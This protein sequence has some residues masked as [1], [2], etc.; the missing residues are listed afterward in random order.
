V[1]DEKHDLIAAYDRFS[2]WFQMIESV[3]YK[4]D[5]TEK[6]IRFMRK[7]KPDIHSILDCACGIGSVAI[8]LAK[9]GFMVSCSDASEGMLMYAKRDAESAGTSAVRFYKSDW[10]NLEENVVGKFDCIINLG[11][12]IYHLDGADLLTAL[13]SMKV[14]LNPGGL[15]IL[16]N[17]NWQEILC[18]NEGKQELRLIEKR[19]IVRVFNG[20]SPLPLNKDKRYYFFDIAWPEGRQWIM[21]V[22]RLPAKEVHELL[23]KKNIA[24]LN[25]DNQPISIKIQNGIF[26]ARYYH[27]RLGTPFDDLPHE[28]I[29]ISGWPISSSNLAELMEQIGF[30][31]IK[32]LDKYKELYEDDS[33]QK[34]GLYDLIIGF[35]PR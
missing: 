18:L 9:N 6:L 8:D 31:S 17:K 30:E 33:H 16:D 14:K 29:S 5:Y 27:N 35:N 4:H 21:K 15:L 13:R 11:V 25:I 1:N 2:E 23:S 34:M 24:F 32:I 20:D 22:V 12:S 7:L 10:Q 3:Y 26:I 19:Q 28:S